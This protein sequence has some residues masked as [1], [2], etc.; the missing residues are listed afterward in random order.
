MNTKLKTV[1]RKLYHILC[2]IECCEAYKY[3]NKLLTITVF[4]LRRLCRLESPDLSRRQSYLNAVDDLP[5]TSPKLDRKK[6]IEVSVVSMQSI[7]SMI[8]LT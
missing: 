6:S 1:N 5:D 2:C 8:S 4:F 3:R 7:I